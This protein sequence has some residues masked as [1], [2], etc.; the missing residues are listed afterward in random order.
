MRAARR[1]LHGTAAAKVAGGKAASATAS[2]P[3][4]W[5]AVRGLAGVAAGLALVAACDVGS[6]PPGTAAIRAGPVEY[7]PRDSAGVV[8]VENAKPPEGS[9]LGWTVSLE[10]VVSIG[11]QEGE[12]E[13][14]LHSVEDATKLA[15]GRIVVANGGSRQLLVFDEAGEYMAAWG[16]PG[17]G[18]GEFGSLNSVARWLGDSIMASD[19]SQNRMTIFHA[20]GSH[21][22]TTKL[23]GRA[24][25]MAAR[26][27]AT[28]GRSAPHVAL[29]VLPGRTLLTRPDDFHQTK[30]FWRQ[31]HVY[32]LKDADGNTVASLGAHGGPETYTESV[33]VPEDRMIYLTPIRHPF[34][35]TTEWAVW[36]ELVA[37][38]RTETYEI[39]AYRSDGTVARI[40]RR[41]NVAPAPTQADLDAGLRDYI[42]SRPEDSRE[43]LREVAPNVPMVE[44]FPAFGPIR[45][46]ALGHLWVAE[47][48]RPGDDSALTTWTVFDQEGV[49]L[50]FVETPAQLDVYEIGADYVLGKT[51]DEFDVEYMQ[52]WAL[53]RE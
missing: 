46:D 9:R 32:E 25:G 5:A 47:F 18:P 38:G 49:A 40:V 21:G 36:G 41:D 30:G 53:E 13:W 24:A 42:A 39:H 43:R 4:A 29:D 45:G 19:V 51:T 2:G 8:V 12:G 22:R 33:D 44:T 20:D 28:L 52:V 34:G 31:E 27:L 14:Q 1:G 26:V 3:W 6:D 7:G 10:P 50:G 48:K 15:D 16:G 11:T 35:K 37:L 17:E 23:E